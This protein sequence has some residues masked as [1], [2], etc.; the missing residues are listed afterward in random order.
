MSR[1]PA[2]SPNSFE[3]RHGQIPEVAG[4]WGVWPTKVGFSKKCGPRKL[5]LGTINF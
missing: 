1:L 5:S 3:D 4:S 2:M